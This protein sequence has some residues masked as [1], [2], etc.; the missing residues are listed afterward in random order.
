VFLYDG[1]VG[2]IWV[3]SMIM[4]NPCFYNDDNNTEMVDFSFCY[5]GNDRFLGSNMKETT[6]M[7]SIIVLPITPIS[8]ALNTTTND[9]DEYRYGNKGN[10]YI[11]VR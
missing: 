10:G 11:I 4:T 8:T 3:L 9:D 7:I 6:R 2:D 1:Y 5:D